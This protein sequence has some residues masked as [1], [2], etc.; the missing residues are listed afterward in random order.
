MCGSAGQVCRRRFA[1]GHITIEP[2]QAA[3]N[4]VAAVRGLRDRMPLIG[5]NHQLHRHAQCLQR[6]IP[7]VRLRCRHLAIAVTGFDTEYQRLKSAAVTFVS[8]P[9]TLKGNR[10]VFFTDPDGNYVHLIERE[11]PIA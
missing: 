2:L 7:L 9:E 10:V 4:D 8:E 3:H 6:V 5:I 1:L 11:K